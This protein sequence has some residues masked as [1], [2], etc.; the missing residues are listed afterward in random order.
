MTGADGSL[1][2]SGTQ[3]DLSALLLHEIGHAL[4]LADNSDV[5]SAMYYQVSGNGAL[6]ANDIQ[7][8]QALYGPQSQAA[9]NLPDPNSAGAQYQASITNITAQ[10]IQAMASF[11]TASAMTSTALSPELLS[12]PAFLAAAHA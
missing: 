4:G 7:G 10:L 11:P 6:D 9:P 5:N 2:Y 1:I 3:T 8:M 12:S